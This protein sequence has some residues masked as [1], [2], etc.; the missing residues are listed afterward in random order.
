VA[1]TLGLLQTIEPMLR[2][3]AGHVIDTNVPLDQ[4]VAS[5]LRLVGER[6]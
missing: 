3:G 2:R 6:A 5:V 4:V 1:R